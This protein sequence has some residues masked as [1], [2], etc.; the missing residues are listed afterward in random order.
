MHD[1]IRGRSSTHFREMADL[2]LSQVYILQRW[3][4][5]LD[6]FLQE[7]YSHPVYTSD[8]EIAITKCDNESMSSIPWLPT[9]G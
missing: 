3:K 2:Q 4:S 8:Q 1:S 5:G 7:N 6:I 9:E